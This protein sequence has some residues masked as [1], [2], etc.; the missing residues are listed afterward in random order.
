M[1][2][3]LIALLPAVLLAAACGQD[4][5][6]AVAPVPSTGAR[7]TADAVKF[8]EAGATVAGV[9]A[10]PLKSARESQS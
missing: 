1:R 5:P 2:K 10:R 9:P 4:S 7:P 3:H 6:D 8:W